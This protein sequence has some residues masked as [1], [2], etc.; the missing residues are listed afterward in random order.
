[1]PSGELLA[2][3]DESGQRSKSAKSSDHFVM[4]AAV[5]R[6][7]TLPTLSTYLAKLRADLHR[8]PRD[9]LTWKNMKHHGERIYIAQSIGSQSWLRMCSV[10]VCKRHIASGIV[11]DDH[12]YLYTF[13][14]LLERL[15]WL[16]RQ[17]DRSVRYTLA[18]IQR[19]P[20]AKLREYEAIL[21]GR[22]DTNI[23]WRFLDPHGGRIDQPQRYEPLQLGDLVAS[24]TAQAFEPDRFGNTEPRYLQEMAPRIWAGPYGQRRLTSYGLKMHPWN[25]ATKAAYPW[26]AAL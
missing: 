24:A 14:F 23:D 20:I 3:I 5:I 18:A 11:N 17:H 8:G 7:E 21:R 4:S 15:S 6:A 13:R 2:F 22:P 9:H 26:V 10:V 1:M 16:G 25:D 12:A 19:F